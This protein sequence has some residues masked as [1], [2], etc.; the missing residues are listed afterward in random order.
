MSG[1]GKVVVAYLNP[2]M[3][4]AEFH[5]SLLNLL[6]FDMAPER[7][8]IVN[9]GGR[10]GVRSG[11][12]LSGSRNG[13]VSRYLAGSDAEW[14]WW[15]DTDMTFEPDTL[16]R[17]LEHADA[18]KAPIVGG[19]CFSVD[20]QTFFPTLYD[21]AQIDGKNEVVRYSEWP[22]NAMFQIAATGTACLLV[23][24]TVFERMAAVDPAEVP[25]FSTVYPWFQE[26]EFMGKAVGE[27]I[28]FCWRAGILEIPVYVNTGVHI[29]H[30]KDYLIDIDRYAAQRAELAR[31]KADE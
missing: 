22:P 23:H 2:G 4:N 19:L 6:V 25:G 31:V 5:E 13:A 29:G 8:R 3:V 10:L 27:D 7:R 1:K 24:R 12:N 9:G 14:F 18:E 30:V 17:L 15:L 21:F 26:R 20:H 16:E 11:P 28:T